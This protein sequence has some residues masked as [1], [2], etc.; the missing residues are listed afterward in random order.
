MSENCETF[1]LECRMLYDHVCMKLVGLVVLM[2]FENGTHYYQAS[3][4]PMYTY[5]R[6]SLHSSADVFLGTPI[7]FVSKFLEEGKEINCD[8]FY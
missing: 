2:L 5:N 7:K 3:Q 4:W 6:N 1:V 8:T